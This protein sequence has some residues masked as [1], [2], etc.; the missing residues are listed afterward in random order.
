MSGG[1]AVIAANMYFCSRNDRSCWEQQ[2]SFFYHLMVL[3]S[4]FSYEA[5]SG[6][7]GKRLPVLGHGHRS[8]PSPPASGEAPRAGAAAALVGAPASRLERGQSIAGGSA[9]RAAS[10]RS[11]APPRPRARTAL[12]PRGPRRT[13]RLGGGPP[14][15]PSTAAPKPARALGGKHSACGPRPRAP[16]PRRLPARDRFRSARA[17]LGFEALARS[18]RRP[19]RAGAPPRRRSEAPPA[20]FDSC[21]GQR[22][23]TPEARAAAER[24]QQRW[25]DA[26]PTPCLAGKATRPAAAGLRRRAC[27]RRLTPNRP[28]D[29]RRS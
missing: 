5:N 29:Q 8:S 6:A 16:G 3:I 23:A 9:S 22:P 15:V 27:R 25:R 1:I 21:R 7:A 24:A 12:S 2:W 4:L 17:I 10:A 20:A 11:R 18:R 28:R 19:A 13:R 14:S 26:K